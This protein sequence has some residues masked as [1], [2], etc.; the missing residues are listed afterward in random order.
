MSLGD[1]NKGAI[2]L[3]LVLLLGAGGYLWYSM[4]YTPAVTEKANAEAAE[5]TA[6]Q[7]LAAAKSELTQA[8]QRI[9]DSKK[10]SSKPDPSLSKLSIARAAVPPEE[11]ID[12]AALVLGEIAERT[13][14]DTR[15]EAG[16]VEGG[17]SSSGSP[18]GEGTGPQGAT[19][20]DVVFTAAGTWSEMLNFMRQVESSAEMEGDVLYSRGRLFNVTRLE[21][22]GDEDS[23]SDSSDD[24]PNALLVGPNDMLFTLTVRMYTSSTENSQSVGSSADPAAAPTGTD[25]N[26][27]PA[28]GAAAPADGSTTT[29][30]A[31]DSAATSGTA[32]AG[33]TGTAP[34]AGATAGATA[35]AAGGTTAPPAT[36]ATT[37]T[38]PPAGGS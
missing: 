16:K 22:G 28:D 15:V 37:S 33:A 31:G 10:E 17:S 29:P 14:V 20:I 8:Q 35:P 9:E 13:G 34:P 19:A 36:S 5:A 3:I 6:Q 24:D 18:G 12:D 25:P 4:L 32:T 21:I 23:S 1:V 2:G 30:P 7:G 38:T 27:A 11:V 26:A